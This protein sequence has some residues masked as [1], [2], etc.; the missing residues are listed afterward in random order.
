M[1]PFDRYPQRLAEL[2]LD[3]AL[4]PLVDHPFNRSK[5]RLKLLE[6]GALGIAVVASALPPYR[7]APVRHAGNDAD[8]LAHLDQLATEPERCRTEGGRLQ[9]WVLQ[10]HMAGHRR[11]DWL[12]ALVGPLAAG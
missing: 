1:V 4:V 9:H 8:W 6:L 12:Q 5:S 10:G 2:Q 11:T 7:D 3:V